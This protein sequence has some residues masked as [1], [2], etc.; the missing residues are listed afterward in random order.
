MAWAAST[1]GGSL[2]AFAALSGRIELLGLDND[3]ASLF[4]EDRIETRFVD[5]LEPITFDEALLGYEDIAFDLIID[6]GLHFITANLN[7]IYALLPRLAA[8]GHMVVEDVKLRSKPLWELV[9]THLGVVGVSVFFWQHSKGL[10]VVI[11]APNQ[12]R[13]G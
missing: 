7:S 10:N 4:S 11:S 6:D 5:Q 1:S 13:A 8:G 3:R 2:R 9:A 12:A